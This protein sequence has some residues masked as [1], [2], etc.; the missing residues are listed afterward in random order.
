MRLARLVSHGVSS[1]PSNALTRKEKP[2]SNS[3]IS[4]VPNCMKPT[5]AEP[6]MINTLP[7]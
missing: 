4:N 7:M 3:A 2:A 1:K 5:S 6:P